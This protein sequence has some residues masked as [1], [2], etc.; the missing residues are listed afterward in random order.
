MV[1]IK[2]LAFTHSIKYIEQQ[3][4]TI[5]QW[6]RTFFIWL[7][8]KISLKHIFKKKVALDQN[9]NSV[10]NNLATDFKNEQT[11]KKYVFLEFYL[12]ILF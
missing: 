9:Y 1:K 11:K 6:F 8:L 4:F 12:F 3:I 5:T 2:N 7:N 10:F